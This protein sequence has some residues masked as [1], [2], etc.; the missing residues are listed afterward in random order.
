VRSGFSVRDATLADLEQITDIKVRNWEDTYGSLLEPEVLRPFLDRR[1]QLAELRENLAHPG[2]LM[3]VAVDGSGDIKGFAVTYV[4]D[5]PE[6]WLESLHVL[7]EFRGSGIG[8]LLMRRTAEEVGARGHSSMR[9]GVI[10]GNVAA[11]RFYER[12]GGTMIGLEPVSWA[13]GVAHEVYRWADLSSL[14]W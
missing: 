13:Q 4:E 2:T 1:A 12:L 5:K 11:A 8:R 7:R 10:S 14:R 9:L 3:L 6:P